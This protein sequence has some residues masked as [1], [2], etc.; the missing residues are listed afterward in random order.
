[1]F[2]AQQTGSSVAMA[3]TMARALSPS[4]SSLPVF[5]T[6]R[7][8]SWRRPQRGGG[9]ASVCPRSASCACVRC[10]PHPAPPCRTASSSQDSSYHASM[11]NFRPLLAKSS[12]GL[13][14]RAR[15]RG[16]VSQTRAGAPGV[17]RYLVLQKNLF[18]QK[19][20]DGVLVA[21]HAGLCRTNPKSKRHDQQT[22]SKLHTTPLPNKKKKAYRSRRRSARE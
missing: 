13:D 2:C 4:S 18:G 17:A 5:F 3:A 8:R 11:P 21:G 7:A 15:G 12:T 1:M 22:A 10:L 9:E 6:Q 19:I 20:A 14:W 16:S